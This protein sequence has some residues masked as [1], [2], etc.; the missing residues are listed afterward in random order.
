MQLNS[1]KESRIPDSD[2]IE[3]NVS[4]VMLA[5]RSTGREGVGNL[6]N[7]FKQS[8]NDKEFVIEVCCLPL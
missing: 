5:I 3:S 7:V 2:T 1:L 8:S 6:I 4:S